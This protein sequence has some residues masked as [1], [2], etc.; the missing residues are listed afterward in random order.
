[1]VENIVDSHNDPS[2]VTS[3]IL[4]IEAGSMEIHFTS[5]PPS[6]GEDWGT[7]VGYPYNSVEDPFLMCDTLIT[8]P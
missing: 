3:V 1:M 7:A 5:P 2:M 6:A 4:E 8:S